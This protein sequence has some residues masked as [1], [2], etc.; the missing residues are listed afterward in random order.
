MKL[1]KS[2]LKQIIKE[3]I[4]KVLSD[5]QEG[6]VQDILKKFRRPKATDRDKAMPKEKDEDWARRGLRKVYRQKAV[7]Y[8]MGQLL[9]AENCAAIEKRIEDLQT[10]PNHVLKQPEREEEREGELSKLKRNLRDCIKKAKRKN[11]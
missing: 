8:D 1:T 3:E 10:N 4:A 7:S 5:L 11:K 2:K 6:R 9:S